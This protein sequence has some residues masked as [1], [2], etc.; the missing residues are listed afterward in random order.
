MDHR[1]LGGG[2]SCIEKEFKFRLVETA[3]QDGNTIVEFS[4][5]MP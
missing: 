1:I 3:K 5:D 4:S 2:A